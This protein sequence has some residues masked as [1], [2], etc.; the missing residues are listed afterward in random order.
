MPKAVRGKGAV[1]YTTR[2]A[3]GLNIPRAC[4]RSTTVEATGAA[5]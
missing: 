4:M 1:S 3:S 5:S 2:S